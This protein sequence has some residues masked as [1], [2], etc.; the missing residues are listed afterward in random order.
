MGE[1]ESKAT[2]N[3]KDREEVLGQ[4]H[5]PSEKIKLE[6]PTSSKCILAVLPPS[7]LD[8]ACFRIELKNAATRHSLPSRCVKVRNIQNVRDSR[9]VFEQLLMGIRAK[10]GCQSTII[11]NLS[12]KGTYHMCY[13]VCRHLR[14]NS[15][16]CCVLG[17][18]GTF[19]GD[20]EFAQEVSGSA[21]G[22]TVSSEFFREMITLL[23]SKA[24]HDVRRVV[25]ARDG[26]YQTDEAK[27][28]LSMLSEKFNCSVDLVEIT[29]SGPDCVRM[30]K[31]RVRC[32]TADFRMLLDPRSQQGSAVH[33]WI[34]KIQGRNW[35][36]SAHWS[37]Q[38]GRRLVACLGLTS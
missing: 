9:Y 35:S 26:R 16:V 30:F 10:L 24:G 5:D 25:V 15:V 38:G 32:Q 34:A 7:D 12:A 2:D 3:I 22:E 18:N 28:L 6:F 19:L 27:T 17:F 37:Y 4:L 8:A 1:N 21:F 13:D 31:K 11:P 33:R 20:T 23:K 29:K 14:K 36:C